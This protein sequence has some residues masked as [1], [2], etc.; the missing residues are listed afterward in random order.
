M[1]DT[2]ATPDVP[3]ASS[4]APAPVT[5]DV[6]LPSARVSSATPEQRHE[7]QLT[8]KLPD[9]TPEPSTEAASSPDKPVEQAPALSADSQ[10]A[11]PPK[12]NA[13]TRQKEL[14]DAIRAEAKRLADLREARA[15]EEGRLEA[16]RQS[17]KPQD[18]P[19]SSPAPDAEPR[20]TFPTFEQFV[21]THADAS[22]EDYIDARTD[23]RTQFT[24]ARSKELEARTKR[25][26]ELAQT[27]ETFRKQFADDPALVTQIA[28]QVREITP[29]SLLPKG[30]A[31]NGLS[32]LGERF[33]KSPVGL[34][35][36]RHFSSHPEDL[37]KFTQYG[38]D[39]F[40]MELGVLERELKAAGEK[41][42]APAAPPIQHT[43]NA[44]PPPVSLG[45]KGADPVDPVMAAYKRGDVAE[46]MRLQNERD[47]KARR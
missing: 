28:P 19:D 29:T 39:E 23:A 27:V 40:Y 25:E 24:E 2:P 45:T 26:T 9:E 18:V 16:L 6:S 38:P 17:G 33:L 15:R 22:Y 20:F 37:Q 41:A 12:K 5:P 34:P 10:P 11:K 3:A 46:Y 13:E 14:Q 42:A 7:W 36:M 1:A 4:A 8:G 47:L 43:T 31:P 35:L 44:P 30:V 21:E 32:E